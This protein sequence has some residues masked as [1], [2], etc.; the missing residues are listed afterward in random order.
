MKIVLIGGTGILGKEL[1]KLDNSLICLD[2]TYDIFI[3]D[4]LRMFLEMENP[5]VIINCAAI[6]S[7]NVDDNIIKSINVNIIGSANLSKYCIENEKRLVYISTDYVYPGKSGNY[8][9][10]DFLM[11][12]N[13]YAWTKLG[14]ETPVMLVKN[15]LIIRTSFGENTFPHSKAFTNLFTSKDYVDIIAP[16]ILK[17]AKSNF[18]GKLNIGTQRKSIF[19]YVN[20]RNNVEPSSIPDSKDF[21]LNLEKYNNLF[22]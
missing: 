14:G 7:G 19:E 15:H 21:S 10:S 9:E 13:N 6:K 2:S 1:N 4:D 20:S 17:T 16:M 12:Q 5:D 3:F 11:P 22:S 8:S 18:V